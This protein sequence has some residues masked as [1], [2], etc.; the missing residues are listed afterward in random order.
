MIRPKAQRHR[1]LISLAAIV[2]AAAACSSADSTP[3]ADDRSGDQT[4]AAA[5]TGAGS[6]SEATQTD[7]DDQPAGEAAGD[8]ADWTV[9]VYVMGDNDLEP[10]AI[11]DLLEMSAV[12]STDRVNIVALVDRH[13]AYINE[14][15][16]PVE[17]FE[18]TRSL[19]IG[20][21][22]I[23]SSSELGELNLGDPETLASFIEAGV[24][25]YPAERYA[26][27]LWNHGAPW[28]GMGPDESNGS[29]ILDLAEI[30]AGF[31]EGLARAGLDSIDLIGFDAC[32]MASY[33]VATTVADHGDFMLAS[34]EL[35]PGHGWNYEALQLLVDNPEYSA[36]DLGQAIIDGFVG[37]AQ[38]NNTEEE[39]TLSLLDLRVMGSVEQALDQLAQPLMANPIAAA[40]I[41]A[42]ART[43]SL[44]FGSNPDPTLDSHQ[45]DLGNLVQ[46]L[47]NADSLLVVPAKQLER[48][49]DQLVVATASGPATTGATGVSIYFPVFAEHFRQG[50]LFLEDIPV[51]PELLTSYYTAGEALPEAEQA[52]FD[53]SEGEAQ[54]FFDEDGLNIF[55]LFNAVAEGNIVAAKIQ[56]GILDES[57]DSI[58]FIGEE[59]GEVSDDGSGIAAAIYDLTVLT[60]SDGEDTDFAYLDLEI[61]AENELLL[62][63]V[64]L[65][66]VPPEDFETDDPPR[67][68]VLSLVTDLDGNV[69][70]E[71]YYLIGPDGTVGE[72]NADPNGLIFPVVLN[73][74]PDG[75]SEWLTLSEQGLWA[76]LPDLQYNLDPLEAGTWL[77]AEL[78]IYDFSG[79]SDYVAVFD[80]IPG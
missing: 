48:A 78:V 38:V 14:A 12:G 39:I 61:D 77:Y 41:L 64:P 5:S 43:A 66:Y 42:Q 50:Y 46:H 59:P 45:I 8:G 35:E 57:D 63:D 26:V 60:I 74:Y 6:D 79:N 22:S 27:V 40:P 34:E 30:N 21:E 9:M 7:D 71:V 51:W 17:E 11:Q 4:D 20:P 54:Y 3:S 18:D 29:D 52:S 72:L 58:I 13:P 33:E 56:Y 75:T 15:V 44:T 68:V 1:L 28:T 73:Q 16:G 80:Q 53:N 55:D 24:S 76:N 69:L 19:Y 65:W 70:S 31:T 36:V 25:D 10:F 2:L 37:Q 47:G 67:D 32:L 49:L 62:I 23:E